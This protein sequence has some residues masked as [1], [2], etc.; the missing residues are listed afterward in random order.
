MKRTPLK[1]KTPLKAKKHVVWRGMLP[2]IAYKEPRAKVCRKCQCRECADCTC[3]IEHEAERQRKKKQPKKT[4]HARRP[5]APV[6]W[7]LFVKS[8]ACFVRRL[9]I[10]GMWPTDP[11]SCCD[12]ID[13]DHMGDRMKA[14]GTRAHDSTCAPICHRHHMQRHALTG[15]FKGFT[16]QSMRAFTATAVQWT[17]NAAR[18]AGVT[19]PDC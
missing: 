16:K 3:C 1:R 10:L 19:I 6:S 5:R 13:A 17:H 4:K 2:P 15:A 9:W 7:W 14:D 8:Q 11:G 12:T 18:A